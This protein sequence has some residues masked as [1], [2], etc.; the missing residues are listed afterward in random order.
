M[1]TNEL[2]QEFSQ[3]LEVRGKSTN[4]IRAYVSDLKDF[5]QWYQQTTGDE[6]EPEVVLSTDITE[7]RSYLQNIKKQAPK[8][9]NRKLESARQF[10]IWCRRTNRIEFSPFETL[11]N[12]RIKV[13]EAGQQKWIG[14]TEQK[15]LLRSV[16]KHGNKRDYA[17]IMM[18]L[19][20]GLRVSELV[21]LD[22]DDVMFGH[23][24][25]EIRVRDGK[26]CKARDIPFTNR[27]ARKALELYLDERPTDTGDALF[28]GQRGRFGDKG[29]RKMVSKYT[30]YDERLSGVS[31]HTLR[32]CYGKRL[33]KSKVELTEIQLLM[34]HSNI[35]MATIYLTPDK[36]DLRRASLQADGDSNIG[37]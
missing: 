25:G 11:D 20:S 7:Y 15:A 14:E 12:Y 37:D 33:A 6:L 4:T 21:S 18:F 24:T 30:K 2:I 27:D 32:H 9:V 10:F 23:G 19:W 28:I 8:T 26:G 16:Q 22:L 17:I 29:I 5:A 34:G 1:N 3:S 13:E 35:E 36:A 31:P